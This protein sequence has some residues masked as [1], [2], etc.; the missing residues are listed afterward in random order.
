[1]L[2]SMLRHSAVRSSLL[3]GVVLLC[4]VAIIGPT[5]PVMALSC[6]WALLT[7]VSLYQARRYQAQR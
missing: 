4:G 5:R 3:A 7:L 6:V 1:M 2:D